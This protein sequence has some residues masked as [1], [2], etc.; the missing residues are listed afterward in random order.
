MLLCFFR[1]LSRLRLS[2]HWSLPSY[3]LSFSV[4]FLSPLFTSCSFSILNVPTVIAD[5]DASPANFLILLRS[6]PSHN[7]T[8]ASPLPPSPPSCPWTNI[9]T[10]QQPDRQQTRKMFK[11]ARPFSVLVYSSFTSYLQWFTNEILRV[12]AFCFLIFCKC[13][14]GIKIILIT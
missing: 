2:N 10:A 7:P 13:K 11:Q 6:V 9:D 1:L 12:I 8:T 3:L 14:C 5:D 4:F